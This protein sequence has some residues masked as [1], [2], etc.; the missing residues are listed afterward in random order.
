M[1]YRTQLLLDQVDAFQRTGQWQSALELC[2]RVFRD[3]WQ[4]RRS[5]DLLEVI[6]RI[7]F[8][9]S[10]KADH[11]SASEHFHLALTIAELKGDDHRAGRSLNGLAV[12]FQSSGNLSEAQNYYAL[13]KDKALKAGDRL[14]AG[15][16]ELNLG[17]LAN[18]RGD[19]HEALDHYKR[20]LSEYDSIHNRSRVARVLNNLGMLYIDLRVYQKAAESLQRGL[21]IAESIQDLTTQG[22]IKANLAELF[23]STADLDAARSTCD[24]A[25]EIASRLGEDA[26]KADVLK[27]YGI[28]YRETKKPRLAESH[29]KQAIE[30]AGEINNPLLI[31]EATREM[32]LVYRSE[33][34]NREAFEAF[35]GAHALFSS[36]QAKQDKEDVDSRLAQIEGDFLSL[37]AQWGESIEAKDRYTSGH[38]QRVADYACRIATAAGIGELELKWFRMGAF[39]HDVGKTEVPAEILNKPGRLTNEERAIIEQ[40]TVVGDQMLA[41]I[42]FPWDIRPMVRSHHERWDGRGYPDG[43]EGD[44]IPFS[45]R[46]LKIADVFDAL[47][48]TRSYRDPLSPMEAFQIMAEDADAYDPDLFELFRPILHDLVANWAGQV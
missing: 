16:V 35:S 23:I 48:T 40:H 37:V 32:A 12:I 30:L 9:Y 11:L 13:A 25:F 20:A 7:A 28:I 39:L 14:T 33:G 15:D 8:L 2:Q 18:I 21:N 45:A 38:C 17:I 5:E 46:I 47:T 29:L 24:D 10:G 36:L 27:Y 43:L 3:S 41:S 4:K 6:L 42:P 1:A 22:I 44:A 19:L 34:R 26:L 31:A